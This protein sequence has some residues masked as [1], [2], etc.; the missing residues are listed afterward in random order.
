MDR[1]A[2]RGITAALCGMIVLSRAVNGQ[3]CSEP[4]YR[5]SAKVD[6]TLATRPGTPAD[7]AR[8]LASWT[9]PD[10]TKLGPCA[11][12]FGREDSVFVL[13][14]WVRRIQLHQGDGD[15]HIELTETASAAVT[16]CLLVEIPPERYGSMYR[17]ARS[18]LATLVDTAHL[19][20]GG[21]LAEPVRARFTGAAFFD[22]HHALT[23]PGG[24]A[25]AVLHGRCNASVRALW[26]LHPIYRVEAPGPR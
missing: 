1:I 2:A 14:G 9:P 12:R 23:W 20:S 5:W 16:E 25:R 4:T 3:A 7:V 24:S 18:A 8:I 17:V 10:P 11:A 21:Y 22:G 19:G 6:T 26:E 13:T 15:W